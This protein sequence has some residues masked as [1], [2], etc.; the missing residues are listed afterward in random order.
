MNG[1]GLDTLAV[2]GLGFIV[3]WIVRSYVWPPSRGPVGLGCV[4]CSIGVSISGGMTRIPE[5][6]GFFSSARKARKFALSHGWVKEGKGFFCPQC[7][8]RRAAF[9]SEAA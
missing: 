4:H 6:M 2:F 3:A 5:E 7:A 8:S 1:Y 9:K